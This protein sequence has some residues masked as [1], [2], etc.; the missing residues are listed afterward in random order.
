MG[1]ENDCKCL[2]IRPEK[3]VD[4][5]L[6]SCSIGSNFL[7][8]IYKTT[9]PTWRALFSLADRNIISQWKY[10]VWILFAVVMSILVQLKI[11]RFYVRKDLDR[12]SSFG[13]SNE[14]LIVT[15]QAWQGSWRWEYCN[16][17]HLSQ[18]H[19]KKFKQ[20]IRFWIFLKLWKGKF[21]PPSCRAL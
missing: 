7:L 13:I 16:I 5:G 6:V 14:I 4:F 20:G 19:P 12:Q 15:L 18:S 17:F 3:L 9:P 2:K 1:V 10:S 21:W 8:F 11:N